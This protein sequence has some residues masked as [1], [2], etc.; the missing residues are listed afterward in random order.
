[1]KVTELFWNILWS[2]FEKNLF[3]HVVEIIGQEKA[4][5]AHKLDSKIRGFL[6]TSFQWDKK[7]TFMMSKICFI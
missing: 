4:D 5:S 6:F 1:M 7:N 2:L 3:Q